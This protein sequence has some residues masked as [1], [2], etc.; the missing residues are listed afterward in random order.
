MLFAL[1]LSVPLGLNSAEAAQPD[2][3][4]MLCGLVASGRLSGLRWPDFSDYRTRVRSFYEPTAYSLAWIRAGAATD[5]ARAIVET[6]QN[7]DAKGLDAEDYD[8]SRWG[9]RLAKLHDAGASSTNA[10]FARFDLALTVSLMRYISDVHLGRVNP[11]WFHATF[12]LAN[13]KD[14]LPGFIHRRLIDATDVKAVLDE[15]EPPYKGY[16]RTEEALRLYLA[17]AH[18]DAGGLLPVPKTP[19][20]PGSRYA[21]VAQLASALRRLGDLPADARMPTESNLYE[22]PLVDAVKH[23]QMRHGLDPDGRPG[24]ATFAQLNTP[25]AFRIRQLQL[26]LERWRWVPHNFPRP[27]IVVNIPEFRLRAMNESFT[28]A[29][30]MKVVVGKAYHHQTPVFAAEMKYVIFRPYWNVPRSIQRA[31]LLPKL[32][33]DRSYLAKNDYEVV[34][35]NDALV[36]NGVVDDA[37]LGALG[38]GQL[39]IRQTPGVTNALGL[40]KFLFPN[41]HNVYLHGTPATKLFSKSRRDFSH[42][43]IRV[44]KPEQLAA[45]VLRDRPEWTPERIANAMNGTKTIQVTLE[46]PTPVLIVYAT[47]VVLESGEVRFFEDI[48]GQDAQIEALLAKGYPHPVWKPAAAGSLRPHE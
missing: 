38:S 26:T 22:G 23:F 40:V 47:A 45:Y 32:D 27:P 39:R 35:A 14:D 31:E 33:R 5:Q 8:G 44:E 36:T 41:E 13:A 18:E 48:Y 29:I 42:G 19:V 24:K 30:E 15:I 9:G 2:D 37:T 10:D 11:G 34:T 43:C 4:S 1:A 25:L 7:A 12:D 46:K 17:M 21:G 20:E 28:T 6:L 16:R 3:P